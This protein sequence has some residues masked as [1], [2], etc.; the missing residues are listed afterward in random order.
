MSYVS[1]INMIAFE[2]LVTFWGEFISTGVVLSVAPFFVEN[3]LLGYRREKTETRVLKPIYHQYKHFTP[4]E[5][6]ARYHF[7]CYTVLLTKIR[8]S[9]SKRWPFHLSRLLYYPCCYFR[10]WSKVPTTTCGITVTRHST[11]DASVMDNPIGMP[12][13]VKIQQ[14]VYVVHRSHSIIKTCPSRCRMYHSFP[15]ITFFSIP[16]R[17]DS[18]K[19]IHPLL[20]STLLNQWIIVVGA[21]RVVTN[22]HV[23][24]IDNHQWT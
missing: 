23:D 1:V 19:S 3:H 17:L 7:D 21:Q 8:W 22:K 6:I 18:L 4:P 24:Y 15:N 10:S 2:E 5:T 12:L 9:I 11:M 13:L 16:F 20:L 14:L